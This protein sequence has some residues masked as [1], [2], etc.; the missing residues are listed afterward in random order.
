LKNKVSLRS[1]LNLI[2]KP[3]NL[4]YV[5]EDE[6]L[7]ITTERRSNATLT[8]T[9]SPV[10]TSNVAATELPV[11]AQRG[12]IEAKSSSTS[13]SPASLSVL[14]KIVD[15]KKQAYDGMKA[16]G[17]ERFVSASELLQAKNDYEVSVARYEQAQRAL[18]YNQLLV[19]LA[20]VE[21][22]Q[23]AEANKAT[24]GAVSELELRKLKIKIDL[25]KAKLSELRE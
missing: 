17:K 25:A 20:E 12:Q 2:L 23:A 22:Q 6:V 14:Q 4:K 10:P 11:A 5:I 9:N 3:L 13:E 16:L 18:K 7:K 1:A 8:F 15:G 19:E 21:L 24:T